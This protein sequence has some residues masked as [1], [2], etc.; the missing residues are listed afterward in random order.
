M[1]VL[2]NRIVT[3]GIVMAPFMFFGAFVAKK[4]VNRI[5]ESQFT[6]LIDLTLLMAGL[7]FLLRT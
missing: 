3:N 2:H 6:V 5:S 7:N 4:I 1:N